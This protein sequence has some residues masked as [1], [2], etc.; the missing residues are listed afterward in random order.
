[1][2]ELLH[3]TLCL[4]KCQTGP[5][6]YNS[7]VNSFFLLVLQVQNQ[8]INHLGTFNQDL[9][10]PK[11]KRTKYVRSCDYLTLGALFSI[12]RSDHQ[13]CCITDSPSTLDHS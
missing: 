3:V 7:L 5:L 10:F 9:R 8:C 12:I 6:Y 2:L 4:V 13:F 11:L 1:M